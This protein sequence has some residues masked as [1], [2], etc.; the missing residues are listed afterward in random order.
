MRGFRRT[1]LCISDL[2]AA[3][4]TECSA[5]QQFL[6][7]VGAEFRSAL[8]RRS[9][10]AHDT[11]HLVFFHRCTALGAGLA[12]GSRRNLRR[13]FFYLGA[14]HHAEH[15]IFTHGNTALGAGLIHLAKT[16]GGN[17]HRLLR[18]NLHDRGLFHNGSL[19]HDGIG[20]F[21]LCTAGGTE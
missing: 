13:R 3:A 21:Y 7:A 2:G 15:L 20:C 17:K 10:A 18:N 4:D 1:P 8:L 9:C 11:E 5:F 19:F 12:G 6:T 16:T 14:T